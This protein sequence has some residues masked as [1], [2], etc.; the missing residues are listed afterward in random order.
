MDQRL[1]LIA[2]FTSRN[3][4]QQRDRV[5]NVLGAVEIFWVLR[6]F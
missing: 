2:A 5:L 3:E 4:V 6:G 1:K